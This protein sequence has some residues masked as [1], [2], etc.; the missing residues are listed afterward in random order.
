[1]TDSIL[2]F[3][4]SPVQSFISEARRA[5]D[6]YAGSRI[7][8]ELAKAAAHEIGKE[9]LIYPARREDGSL[10]DDVPN[11]LVA[12]VPGAQAGEIATKA[13][14]ALL[15]KWREDI[16]GSASRAL[17]ELTE[18]HRL[19]PDER[20]RDIWRRQIEGYWEVYWVV[21]PIKSND[22]AGYREAYKQARNAL[23]A[24]KR[25]RLFDSAEE[26]G[27]KDSLSGK[28]EALH[29][30]E[31]DGKAYWL[32]VSG[33]KGIRA[34]KLKPEGRERLDA[35]GAVKRFSQLAETRDFLSTS[36]V[37]A[38][39]FLEVA[40]PYLAEYREAVKRVLGEYIY[41]PR[42]KDPDWRYDGDLLFVDT[43]TEERLKASYGGVARPDLLPD[44]RRALLA[45]YDRA[46]PHPSPYY[47]VIA[48]D[49]DSMG[50][51]I[52]NCQ[53]EDEH[54]KVSEKLAA[55]ASKV[56]TIVPDGFRVYNGGDDVLALSPLSQA[57]ALARELAE[58]FEKTT[59][60]TASAGIAIAHHLYPLDAA[61]EAARGAEKLAKK[62]PGKDAVCVR[63]LK[64]S[65]ETMDARS[66]WKAMG[67]V[68]GKVMGCFRNDTL[69]SRFAYDVLRDGRIVTALE[70][71]A[72]RTA[73]L[74]RL[75]GRHKT[76]ALEKP[77]EL[78][79]ELRQWTD[80]LDESALSD[81]SEVA[82]CREKQEDRVE[83]SPQGFAELG[84]WLAL[85][86]FVARGGGE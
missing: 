70:D 8:V 61:L 19:K 33:L 31:L 10:P 27:Y 37:A 69:S 60:R 22:S 58:Q 42:E 54:S 63:V 72:T 1:M 21:A 18:T 74:K 53:N 80:A 20:W 36:S 50:E 48:L 13:K 9:R 2:V 17:T 71:K 52:S 45:A 85:T 12:R 55:F 51:W 79:L 14:E 43:L 35:I 11:V 76:N 40:R 77:D 73:T 83:R 82:T 64:R 44:A 39:D 3:T 86:R 41:E 32:E 28:R 47:A 7:L 67:E 26:Q 4:F 75:V 30:R 15:K 56:N 78:V 23:N 46:K 65:G 68:F 81:L 24:V 5:A 25:S 49:G 34:A 62:V 66:K 38:S 57:V 16:A 59:G 29:T 84:H 6:L